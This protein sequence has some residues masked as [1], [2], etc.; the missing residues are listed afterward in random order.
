[1]ADAQRSM[2]PMPGPTPPLLFDHE[3]CHNCGPAPLEALGGSP[4]PAL[5]LGPR[6]LGSLSP[7]G[8]KAS[9]VRGQTHSRV[10][11]KRPAA[12]PDKTMTQEAGID[13]AYPSKREGF[14]YRKFQTQTEVER[15]IYRIP[16]CRH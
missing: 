7:A 6:G 1:M 3:N 11:G 8:V 5:A 14:Y 13:S 4:T 2:V 15:I 10:F 9:Q 12:V 16:K